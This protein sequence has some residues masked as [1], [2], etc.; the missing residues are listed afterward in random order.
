LWELSRD[1]TG[2]GARRACLSDMVLLTTYAH[3]G[4]RCQ[5]TF[6][7]NTP[8]RLVLS[9]ECGKGDF[10][11]SEIIVTTPRSLKLDTQGFHAGEPYDFTI[12]ARRVGECAISPRR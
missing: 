9:L 5:R 12:Y 10:G 11:R 4:D 8:R 1:A 2:H 6:L 7:V 3:A